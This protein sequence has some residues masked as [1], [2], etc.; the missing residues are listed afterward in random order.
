M[1]V[2][3]QVVRHLKCTNET[4]KKIDRPKE[5]EGVISS[6]EIIAPTR[7]AKIIQTKRN[8]HMKKSKKNTESKR[9]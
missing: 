7:G 9:G 2:C 5:V 8:D 1:G 3:R 4:R 6:Q